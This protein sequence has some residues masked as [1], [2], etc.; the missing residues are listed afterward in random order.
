MNDDVTITVTSVLKG[1][2]N[3]NGKV[4]STDATAVLRYAAKLRTDFNEFSILAADANQNG[5]INA[6]DAT[7]ILNMAAQ[8]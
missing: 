6:T 2:A 3:L 5:K 4:N 8:L 7:R 1:D